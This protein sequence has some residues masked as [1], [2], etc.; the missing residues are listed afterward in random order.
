MFLVFI[1]PPKYSIYNKIKID[2]VSMIFRNRSGFGKEIPFSAGN[3]KCKIREAIIRHYY[4]LSIS[5]IS[6]LFT[7]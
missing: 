5:A 1:D 3:P 4:F 7:K 6:C 2:L